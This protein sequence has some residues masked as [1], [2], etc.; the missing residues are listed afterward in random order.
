MR[1]EDE[2]RQAVVFSALLEYHQQKFM[3]IGN[4][5]RPLK[6][7]ARVKV[8]WR[9]VLG[10]AWKGPFPNAWC[11]AFA[12]WSLKEAGLAPGVIQIVNNV[13]GKGF[14]FCEPCALPH[15]PWTEAQPGDVCY[16]EKYQHHAILERVDG[17]HIWTVDGNQPAIDR[18]GPQGS[19][20]ARHHSSVAVFYSIAPFITAAMKAEKP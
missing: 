7:E 16:F 8:Y 19:L 6:D 3:R 18:H 9:R 15:V 4:T 10:A 17:E 13:N 14:G 12:L 1:T 20:P 5:L 2:M 11:A